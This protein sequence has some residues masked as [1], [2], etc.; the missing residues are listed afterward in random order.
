MSLIWK[1]SYL[2]G[3]AVNASFEIVADRS[4]VQCVFQEAED[5]QSR[6]GK[7]EGSSICASEYLKEFQEMEAVEQSKK[8]AMKDGLAKFVIR[9]ARGSISRQ[10]RLF[11]ISH[12]LSPFS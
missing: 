9:G 2:D 4:H 5:E 6:T 7:S 11:I 3:E 12:A 10:K 8:K 1:L